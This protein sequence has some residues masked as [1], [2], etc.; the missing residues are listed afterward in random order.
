MYE[1]SALFLYWDK[2][3]N[4]NSG[5]A[6]PAQYINKPLKCIHIAQFCLFPIPIDPP[7]MQTNKEQIFKKEQICI[8]S[9]QEKMMLLLKA[10]A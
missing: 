3:A 2:L 7:I 1:H 5:M 9:D 4:P 6:A 8:N 10:R